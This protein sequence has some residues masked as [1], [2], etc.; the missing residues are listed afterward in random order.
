MMP[1]LTTTLV[2]FVCQSGPEINLAIARFSIGIPQWS[3][4]IEGDYWSSSLSR[5]EALRTA[6]EE[7]CNGVVT[8][9]PGLGRWRKPCDR[10]TAM[11]ALNAARMVNSGIW[12]E[13]LRQRRPIPWGQ[14]I[15]ASYSREIQVAEAE[16]SRRLSNILLFAGLMPLAYVVVLAISSLKSSL[17]REIENERPEH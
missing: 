10:E 8:W 9:N 16:R 11:G 6:V 2:A 13:S 17:K 14:F 5:S 1:L 12:D 4:S 7:S 3:L 15:S